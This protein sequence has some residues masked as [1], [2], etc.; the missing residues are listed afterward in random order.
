LLDLAGDFGSGA[1]SE[2]TEFCQRIFGG[3]S[4]R[5]SGLDSDQDRAFGVLEGR[6]W[7]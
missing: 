4:V 7:R 5:G 6:D 3:D 1:L 2:I